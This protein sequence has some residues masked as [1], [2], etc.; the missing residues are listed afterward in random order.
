MG[1]NCAL[2]LANCFCTHE[3][4]LL[5]SMNKSNKRLVKAFNLTSRCID[6]L[7]SIN[8][9][10]FKQ[11]LKNICPEEL[12][13]SETSESRNVVSYLGLLIDISIGDFVCSIFDKRD[14]FDLH[15]VNLPELF[16]TYQLVVHTSHS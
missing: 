15:I 2:L 14:A 4:K 16:G 3:V 1:T 12:V 11:F 13:V 8:N 7:I 10:R 9:P 6:D 5:R